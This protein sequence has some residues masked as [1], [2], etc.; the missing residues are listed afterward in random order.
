[1]IKL[2]KGFFRIYIM[3]MGLSVFVASLATFSVGVSPAIHWWINATNIALASTPN[4][5]HEIIGLVPT[6]AF[7]AMLTLTVYGSFYGIKTMLN[8]DSL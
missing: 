3:L 1:M 6:F 2:I 8:P 4:E 7:L 5:I